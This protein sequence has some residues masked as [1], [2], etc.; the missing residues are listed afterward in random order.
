MSDEGL[1]I[2]DT[3]AITVTAKG[4][5]FIRKICMVFDRYITKDTSEKRFSKA[6]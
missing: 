5:I 6:I 1:I 2:V 3:D 4:R